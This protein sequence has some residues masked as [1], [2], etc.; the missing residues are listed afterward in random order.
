MTDSDCAPVVRYSLIV[1]VPHSGDQRT[2]APRFSP[3]DG[4][5]LSLVR[6]KHAVSGILNNVIVNAAAFWAALRPRLNVHV[7]H[8]HSLGLESPSGTK[9]H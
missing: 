8:I 6:A 7:R 5:R 3:L 4:L 1:Q 9:L 2:M